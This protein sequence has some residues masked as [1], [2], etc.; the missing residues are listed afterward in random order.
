[1]ADAPDSPNTSSSQSPTIRKESVGGGGV[2]RSGAP[3][4]SWNNKKFHE[5]FERAQNAL[6]DKD[7]DHSEFSFHEGCVV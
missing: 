4:S 2:E 1:M 3:G 7:F 5:E 6:V